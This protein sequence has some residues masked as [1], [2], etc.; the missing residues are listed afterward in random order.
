MSDKIGLGTKMDRAEFASSGW[1][2]AGIIGGTYLAA[3][4]LNPIL[5]IPAAI[6]STISAFNAPTV[7]EVEREQT[8]GLS[9]EQFN[10]F[11]A[12]A[13]E[14][15]YS[16]SDQKMGIDKARELLGEMGIAESELSMSITDFTL[17]VNRLGSDFDELANSARSVILAE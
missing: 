16:V 9:Y 17:Q 1:G 7:E 8:G 6:L 12:L 14:K 4:L 2:K 5:A 3:T 15:G 13:A 11:A 10:E